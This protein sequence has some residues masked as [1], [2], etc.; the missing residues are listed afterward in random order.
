M[1][2]EDEDVKIT[3]PPEQ[4]VVGPLVEIVGTGTVEPMEIMVGRDVSDGHPPTVV[5]TV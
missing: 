1:S 3:D 5:V 2:I 4:N